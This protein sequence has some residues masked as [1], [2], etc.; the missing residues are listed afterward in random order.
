M[1]QNVIININMFCLS[2]SLRESNCLDGGRS[3]LEPGIPLGTQTLKVSAISQ[4]PIYRTSRAVKE[5][6]AM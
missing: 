5:Q 4:C 2:V 3:P 6:T 1:L